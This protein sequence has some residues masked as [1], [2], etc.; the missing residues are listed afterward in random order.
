MA[1]RSTKKVTVD[2]GVDISRIW[3]PQ[4]GPQVFASICPA[5]MILFGGSR[6]GGKTDCAIGRQICG[7]LE[8]G[9]KWNGLFI[10]KSYKYFAELRRRIFELIRLG[11]PAELK[12]SAQSTNYLRFANGA[13][14]MLTVIESMDKAEFFQGQ[15]FCV[16]KGTLIRMADGTGKEIERVVIGDM[17]AT[18]EG[19]RRVAR[20]MPARVSPCVR[21]ETPFGEQEHPTDHPIFSVSGWQSYSSVLGSDSRGVERSSRG[22]VG[23]ESVDVDAVFV[24]R[25]VDRGAF[26]GE[27]ASGRRAL[28]GFL[29]LLNL[30][31]RFLG[32]R[33]SSVGGRSSRHRRLFLRVLGRSPG[34]FF[35]V[36]LREPSCGAIAERVRDFGCRCFSGFRRGGERVRLFRGFYRGTVPSRGGVGRRSPGFS[37]WRGG[38]PGSIRGCIPL[39]LSRYEHPYSGRMREVLVE[40]FS[41]ACRMTPCG[42]RVVYDLTVDEANHYISHKTGLVNKNT[43]ISIEEACQFSFIDDLIE[44]LK[45]CMRSP[46]GLTTRMFLTA[47]PGGPGHNQVKAR[48]MPY[49][50]KP[51]QI[52]KDDNGMTSVFIPSSVEDNKILCENDPE[53]VALL[54]SIKDPVLRR[55]WLDGDWDVV[56]GGFFS[57]IWNKF[58][59]VV[60]FF[61]PPAHWP[62]IV[63]M[64]WGSSTPFSIGWY[65]V[66]DGE[67][68]IVECGGRVFPKNALI[69]FY[70]WYGCPKGEANVGLKM[71]STLVATRMLELED[72]KGLLGCGNYD[73]VADPSIFAEKDGPS[74]AEKFASEG[75][76][77]RRAENKR[78]SGWDQVRSRLRGRCVDSQKGIVVLPDG[79]IEE[80]VLSE[81]WEP[82]LY[83]TENCTQLIRTLPIQERDETDWEDVDCFV[84]GTLI[85]TSSGMVKIEDIVVGDMVATPIGLRTVTRSFCSGEFETY[86]IDF[87]DG[88]SLEGTGSHKVMTNSGLLPLCLIGPDTVIEKHKGENLCQTNQWFIEG[89]GL[90]E[91]AVEDIGSAIRKLLPSMVSVLASFTDLSIQTYMERLQRICTSTTLT[92]IQITTIFQIW[93]SLIRTSML[94]CTSKSELKPVQIQRIH[95]RLLPGG[96]LKKGG[97]SF[98]KMLGLCTKILPRENLRALIVASLLELNIHR[99]TCAVNVVRSEKTHE[100]ATDTLSTFAKYVDAHT[101]G[102][103]SQGQKLATRVVT[104]VGGSYVVAEKKPVYSLEVN[105]SR[106]Y[107]ANNVLVSNTSGEDHAADELRYCCMSR[108]SGG[109]SSSAMEKPRQLTE[110]EL[111]FAL[112]QSTGAGRGVVDGL[113]IPNS[114]GIDDSGAGCAGTNVFIAR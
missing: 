75:V 98:A 55:A 19:P 3:S 13:Q 103:E 113:S 83:V 29:K 26:Q 80:Q 25:I 20:V 32:R 84:S 51:G 79:S 63:A 93:N 4:P 109:I 104:N 21:V 22:S 65:A 5:R 54:R 28:R 11:L 43:E 30:S 64:D 69:R 2:A 67:T 85:E 60:P 34:C 81:K 49:G 62:R 100:K 10:R 40:T 23:P 57:D 52:M 82:M 45:G 42:D 27:R 77:W 1:S 108:P 47:N 24:P 111:D 37:S 58:Q 9:H 44:K 56:L 71:T 48:F 31:G 59:H 72:R 17:V 105:Q 38:D 102:T 96:A 39:N 35:R 101:Q 107:Y 8:Y 112:A 87:T 66:S 91:E 89:F 14:V 90:H 33:F 73:R 106:L 7:A 92:E 97:L 74:I 94:D 86:R 50:V 78:I 46:H 6:G 88:T 95:L 99:N 16:A 110:C 61:R 18:L 53:Y 114:F 76:V 36:L 41:G 15:Q 68:S 12:G 70:E